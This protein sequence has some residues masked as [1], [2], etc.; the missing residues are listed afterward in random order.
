[1]TKE[2]QSK[3]REQRSFGL[4]MNQFQKGFQGRDL[5]IFSIALSADFL[6]SSYVSRGG[7]EVQSPQTVSHVRGL[8]AIVSRD[9]GVLHN[10]RAS[11]RKQSA[12]VSGQHSRSLFLALTFHEVGVTDYVQRICHLTL[13]SVLFALDILLCLMFLRSPAI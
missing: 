11:F 12:A 1:M 2:D 10:W 5:Q 4:V 7:G 8:T 9:I 13:L 6:M 3:I